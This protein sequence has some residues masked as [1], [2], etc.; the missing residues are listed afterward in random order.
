MEDTVNK[1]LLV[2]HVVC[3]ASLT[4]TEWQADEMLSLSVSNQCVF[5]TIHVCKHQL[6]VA[7]I[8]GC[9]MRLCV[10][11]L[12]SASGAWLSTIPTIYGFE[13]NTRNSFRHCKHFADMF[14]HRSANI[15]G[16]TMLPLTHLPICLHRCK[17][18]GL[19]QSLPRLLSSV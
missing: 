10:S 16:T 7:A 5:N 17:D 19:Q 1:V 6:N 18:L 4:D 3:N 13:L 14:C 8:E 12:A 15:Y 2:Y 9:S 11:C